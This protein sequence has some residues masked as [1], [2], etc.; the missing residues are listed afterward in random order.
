MAINQTPGAAP[1]TENSEDKK[2]NEEKTTAAQNNARENAES[3]KSITD[4]ALGQVKDKAAN[5]LDGQKVKLTSGLS[6]V[7][8][9]IRKVS[10]N[11]LDSEDK[12]E[13]EKMTAEYGNTLAQKIEGISDY[14]ENAK[15]QDI[16]RDIEGFARRQPTLFIGAAFALGFLAARFMKTSSPNQHSPKNTSKN[17]Q[18][19]KN[20]ANQNTL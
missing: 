12:S 11:L 4:N 17:R 20:V 8:D 10:E 5:V 7:A 14:V 16:S 19:G 13:I 1:Q 2:I 6:G 18:T 15:L 9:S 3:A